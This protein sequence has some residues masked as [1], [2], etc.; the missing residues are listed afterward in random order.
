MQHSMTYALT[1][2]MLC[3]QFHHRQ[4]CSCIFVHHTAVV[5]DPRLCILHSIPTDTK[6]YLMQQCIVNS[7]S[8]S[9]H[10]CMG[11]DLV[12]IGMQAKIHKGSQCFSQPASLITAACR[13]QA[14]SKLANRLGLL[15]RNSGKQK[16]QKQRKR[17]EVGISHSIRKVSSRLHRHRHSESLMTSYLRMQAATAEAEVATGRHTD[18]QRSRESFGKQATAVTEV[19]MGRQTDRQPDGHVQEERCDDGRS[20]QV[21]GYSQASQFAGQRDKHPASRLGTQRGAAG[22]L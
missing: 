9:N 10:C 2:T 4:S 21:S 16:S 8:F 12:T 22:E 6:S 11:Y 5:N 18:G 3:K 14:A 7:L 1:D 17:P 19:A 13:W 15:S 20:V